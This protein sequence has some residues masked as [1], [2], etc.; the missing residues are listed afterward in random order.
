MFGLFHYHAYST[1]LWGL[2]SAT[3]AGLALGLIYQKTHSEYAISLLHALY[4]MI[5]VM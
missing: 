1:S 5:A 2:L 3:T 4:N